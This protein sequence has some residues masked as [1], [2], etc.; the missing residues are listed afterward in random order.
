MDEFGL[1]LIAFEG[2][3]SNIHEILELE[4]LLTEE[5]FGFVFAGVGDVEFVLEIEVVGNL[6]AIH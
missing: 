3:V 4:A 5:V 1:E 6:A 2:A